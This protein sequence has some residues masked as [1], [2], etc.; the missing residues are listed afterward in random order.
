LLIVKIFFAYILS[1]FFMIIFLLIKLVPV[2]SIFFILKKFELFFDNEFKL[3]G[4]YVE[5]KINNISKKIIL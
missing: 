1:N 3:L 4:V 5:S 2:T